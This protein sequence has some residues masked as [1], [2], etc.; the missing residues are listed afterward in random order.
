MSHHALQRV[1]VRMLHDPGFVQALP[2]VSPEALGLTPQEHAW[3]TAVDPRAWRTDP[4]R[5]SRRLTSLI[6]E[7]PVSSAYIVRLANAETL[8]AFF[9]S[10]FFHDA[11]QAR[12]VLA[13]AFGR[14]LVD[15]PAGDD[16]SRALSTLEGAIAQVR[17]AV[18]PQAAREAKRWMTPPT[19]APLTLPEGTLDGYLAIRRGLDVTTGERTVA[20]AL[21]QKTPLPTIQLSVASEHL[22]VSDG[23][24]GPAI[25]V[26]S[27]ALI[28][29]LKRASR[30]VSEEALVDYLRSEGVDDAVDLL[31]ELETEGLLLRVAG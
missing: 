24:A 4:Y 13:H 15:L 30:P 16:T 31:A 3:A 10:P 7:F 17:R 14:Y 19:Q 21:D 29:L 26:Q 18:V 8:D 6:E 9:S 25:A 27:D 11:V 5:R 22:L 2:Q 23:P 28:G 1:V 20:T 12:S